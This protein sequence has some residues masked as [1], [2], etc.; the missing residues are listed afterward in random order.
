[1]EVQAHYSCLGIELILWEGR[2]LDCVA[3]DETS[4]LL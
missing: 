1:V 4:V 2:V 3:A